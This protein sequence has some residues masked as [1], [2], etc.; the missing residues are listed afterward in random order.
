MPPPEPPV[1]HEAFSWLTTT[2]CPCPDATWAILGSEPGGGGGIFGVAPAPNL[3][4]AS[5][6]PPATGIGP[7]G[8]TP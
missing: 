1:S 6:E 2:V 7:A 8:G 4:P 3:A 5:K